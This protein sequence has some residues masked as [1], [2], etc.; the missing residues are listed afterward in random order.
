MRGKKMVTYDTLIDTTQEQVSSILSA[1]GTVSALT[2]K[3]LPGT[4]YTDI[5]KKYGFPYVKVE[6][7]TYSSAKKTFTTTIVTITCPI[8]CYNTQ[9]AKGRELADAVRKA[10]TDARDTFETVELDHTL[11]PNNSH[12]EALLEDSKTILYTDTINSV[13]QF[14]GEIDA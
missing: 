9:A 8:V 3:I 2:S 4:P 11:L 5:Q 14:W 6:T 1:N 12:G 7:P 10:I 13:F